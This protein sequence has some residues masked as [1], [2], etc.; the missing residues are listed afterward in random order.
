MKITEIHVD[1][2]GIWQEL[3]LPTFDSGLNVIYGPNETGKSTLM[4]FVRGVL[5]GFGPAIARVDE[6]GVQSADSK[7]SLRTTHEGQEYDIH[8]F[9]RHGERGAV[10]INGFDE[11]LRAE[12]VVTQLLSNTSEAMFERLFAVDLHELQELASLAGDELADKV[13]G[14]TL[15]PEGR[16]ILEMSSDLKCRRQELFDPGENSGRLAELFQQ[17]AQV[18]AEIESVETQRERHLVLSHERDE[19]QT[20]IE[21]R[22]VL[23]RKLQ[24]Q[25]Q[26]H[27]FLELAWPVWNQMRELHC[28]LQELPTLTG[29]PEDGLN[30]LTRIDE[31]IDSLAGCDQSSMTQAK[32]LH[33]QSQASQTDTSFL[34]HAA[35]VEAV[36]SHRE[37]LEILLKDVTAAE[38]LTA[39]AAETR[40]ETARQLEN[41]W[42][43]DRLANADTSPTAQLRLLEAARSYHGRLDRR[44]RIRRR[45]KKRAAACSRQSRDFQERLKSAGDGTIAEQISAT[46]QRLSQLQEL[47]RMRLREAELQQRQTALTERLAAV[48]ESPLLPPWAY[49]VLGFFGVVGV[50]FAIVGF[51]TGLTANGIVGLMYALLGTAC[52]GTAYALKTHVESAAGDNVKKLSDELRDVEIRLRELREEI[53]RVIDNTVS[54]AEQ[55]AGEPLSASTDFADLPTDELIVQQTRQLTD[56]ERMAVTEE[57]ITKRR[58]RLSEWRGS[59]QQVQRDVISARQSWREVLAELGLNETLRVGEAFDEWRQILEAREVQRA[60]KTAEDELC[61]CRRPLDEIRRSIGQLAEQLGWDAV[62]K[63]EPLIVL[64]VWREELENQQ[65]LQS[66]RQSLRREA[67]SNLRRAAGYRRRIA[68]CRILRADLL[69]AGGASKR[70]EFEDNEASILRRKELES[71]LFTASAELE[72]VCR[73]EPELAIVEEDMLG[74]DLADNAAQLQ[75]LD[76]SLEQSTSE[77]QSVFERLGSVKQELAD[78]ES[79]RRGTCL[80]FDRTR[81]EDELTRAA[82]EWFALELSGRALSAMQRQ[83]ERDHQPAT[84]AAGTKYLTQMTRGRYLS[85][86][87]PLGEQLLRVDDDRGRSFLVNQLSG[88]TR[89]QLFLAIRLAIVEE[90]AREGV[91]LPMVLDDVFANFDQSRTEAAVE[92]LLEFAGRGQQILLLTCHQHLAHMLDAHGVNTIWLPES[93]PSIEER[94]AG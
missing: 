71:A 85:I 28:E 66:E 90:L 39:Q 35:E 8:R 16:A 83:F 27:R 40:D 3:T 36:C 72:T 86:W 1:R 22:K 56:L 30:R 23:Q 63:E 80:R 92:T 59:L 48:D 4:R 68:K 65:R 21:R 25:Q 57:H 67:R 49:L 17:Q 69:T 93:C 5:Y 77:L 94:R 87:T 89:E 37:R 2:F 7:G 24:S 6:S 15:G 55:I 26:G 54:D 62:E 47:I 50:I 10:S 91:E 41:D 9:A 64:D 45:Y 12:A 14:L 88:G 73:T 81:I 29:F 44:S 32:R 46:K 43:T 58:Q 52:G 60:W 74:F 84:L 42:P 53:T 20:E 19:L 38:Q 31:E 33:R 79:D 51:Y 11:E 75:Q 13:Y 34:R 82:E 76:E 61:S 78:L 70:E 18:S